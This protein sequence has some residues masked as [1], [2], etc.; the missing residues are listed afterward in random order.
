MKN[1]YLLPFILSIFA[2]EGCY[3]VALVSVESNVTTPM[4]DIDR[5][6]YDSPPRFIDRALDKMRLPEGILSK[7][8]YSDKVMISCLNRENPAEIGARS[9]VDR[10][11]ISKL[12]S[13]N[14]RV[15]ER[16]KHLIGEI[17]AES[18]PNENSLWHYYVTSTGDSSKT[19][20]SSG[21]MLY[22]AKILAYRIL[23]LGITQSINQADYD[24]Y[25][26]GVAELELRLIDVSTSQILYSGIVT[27]VDEDTITNSEYTLLSRMH[28]RYYPDDMLMGSNSIS[29]ASQQN[30]L[31]GQ[32]FAVGSMTFNFTEG[33]Q[34]TYAYIS[35]AGTNA[36]V[37]KI[38]IPGDNPGSTFSYTWNLMNDPAQRIKP[39]DYV[40]WLGGRQVRT[41]HIGG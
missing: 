21:S 35:D 16:S 25:R 33:V 8:G 11:I 28:L 26:F 10:A 7:L 23:D 15:I 6:I 17:L 19:L 38:E 1:M 37:K 20:K 12:L 4:I 41:F 22:P 2:F 34:A 3:H 24:I 5:L 32:G 14:T 18:L 36:L 27:S 31:S 40:L 13:G 39:G 29:L 9:A 30:F